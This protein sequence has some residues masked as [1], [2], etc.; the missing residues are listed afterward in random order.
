MVR[1]HSVL[2]YVSSAD[3]LHALFPVGRSLFLVKVLDQIVCT[4]IHHANFFA[5]H[6]IQITTRL[7]YAQ[8][9]YFRVSELYVFETDGRD[10]EKLPSSLV[11]ILL[12]R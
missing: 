10:D 9:T 1:W 12:C 8:T 7:K 4:V 3:T 6:A 5:M 2:E 11:D